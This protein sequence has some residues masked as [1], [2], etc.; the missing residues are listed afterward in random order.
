[1]Q[2]INTMLQ[3]LNS[4][5]IYLGNLIGALCNCKRADCFPVE[6]L[7]ACTTGGKASLQIK[8]HLH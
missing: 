5:V 8:P 6:T 3:T 4:G 1:M 7:Y 2:L